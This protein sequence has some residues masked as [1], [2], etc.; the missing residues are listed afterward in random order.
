VKTFERTRARVR[1]VILTRVTAYNNRDE[2]RLTELVSGSVT[3][4]DLSGIPT[5]ERTTGRE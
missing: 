3:V 1:G 5:S 4:D 2:R